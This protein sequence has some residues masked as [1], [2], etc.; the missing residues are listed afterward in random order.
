M[1]EFPNLPPIRS[2]GYKD[3][4]RNI[5]WELQRYLR[6]YIQGIT[7]IFAE[8]YKIYGELHRDLQGYIQR[9]AKT[10]AGIY[11]ENYKDICRDIYR[12]LQRYLQGYLQGI[13]KKFA[14]IFSIQGI[15][16]FIIF[17]FQF[18]RQQGHFHQPLVSKKMCF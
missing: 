11:I 5:Y 2:E 12:E 3:I 4:C 1:I 16:K 8:I 14:G 17:Q 15:N 13:T 9:I 7:K 6:G 18:N 10:F